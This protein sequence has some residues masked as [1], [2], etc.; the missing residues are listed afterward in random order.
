MGKSSKMLRIKMI[1]INT[2][3]RTLWRNSGTSTV[4]FFLFPPS[5][6][7]T[8]KPFLLPKPHI[9][10]TTSDVLLHLSP[11]LESVYDLYFKLGYPNLKQKVSDD[12]FALGT[13]LV[14]FSI[15]LCFKYT[16]MVKLLRSEIEKLQRLNYFHI[17]TWNTNF[18]KMILWLV[19]KVVHQLFAQ[20]GFI[21]HKFF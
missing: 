11:L 8:I 2:F 21:L 16:S 6:A 14:H 3:P 7:H 10:T 4:A 19:I 9:H 13:F 17:P 12:N 15:V 5:H 18:K 20:H 1:R